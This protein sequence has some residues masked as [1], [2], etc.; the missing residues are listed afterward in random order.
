[1]S[2]QKPLS[3]INPGGRE[4]LAV[5]SVTAADDED[6]A[7]PLRARA[8]CEAFPTPAPSSSSCLSKVQPDEAGGSV[9]TGYQRGSHS[10]AEAENR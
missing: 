7:Y 1:M 2:A 6:A 8:V 9:L 5:D 4:A 10:K 3:N